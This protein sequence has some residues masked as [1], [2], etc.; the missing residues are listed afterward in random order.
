MRLMGVNMEY[1]AICVLGDALKIDASMTPMLEERVRAAVRH[2]HFGSTGKLIMSGG[3]PHRLGVT[4]AEKMRDYA[5]SYDVLDAD[6]IEEKRSL[7]T[8]GNAYF[9][10]TD[11]LIPNLWTVIGMLTSSPK[12]ERAKLIFKQVLGPNYDLSVHSSESNLNPADLKNLKDSES[13]LIESTYVYFFEGVKPGDDK[14]NLKRLL[15]RSGIYVGRS[16]YADL[17]VEVDS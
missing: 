12:V 9:T 2:Y 16:E 17:R 5:R 11:V 13:R 1:E 15:E 6:I 4:E 7:D 14:A 8:A 3:D 10:K